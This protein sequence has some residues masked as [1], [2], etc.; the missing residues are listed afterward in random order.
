[1]HLLYSNS[2]TSWT[3]IFNNIDI[4][5]KRLLSMFQI[6][7]T[8]LLSNKFQLMVQDTK[9]QS[10]VIDSWYYWEYELYIKL[11]N[12]KNKEEKEQQDKQDK[13]QGDKYSNMSN[14][15]PNKMM[16]AYNPSNLGGSGNSAFP[17]F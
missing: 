3:D 7:I 12:Q 14:F 8:E 13:E 16:S 4:F 6:D 15:N 2:Q 10:N 17:R 11:L 5:A 1:M 9:A